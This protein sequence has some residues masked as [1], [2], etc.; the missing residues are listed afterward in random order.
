MEN[1]KKYAY[2]PDY[3][4]PPGSTLHEVMIDQGMSQKELALRTG[5]TP[6]TLIRIFK[7]EQPIT[8]E[9]AAR[10]ELVTGVPARFWNNLEL[11]YRE[12]QARINEKNR[13]KGYISWLK[14][15]PTNE[16]RQRGYLKHSEN[17]PELLRETLA[18]F[19][20]SSVQSWHDLWDEPDVAARRSQC[21]ESSPGPT[22][23]W[24][25]QGELHALK[26][27]CKPYSKETFQ[28]TLKKI[29]ILTKE[30]PEVFEPEVIKLCAESGIALALVP[31]M[32]K[33]PWSGATK[34]LSPQKALI[35]LNLRG[36]GEDKFWFSFFHEA[37]HVLHDSKKDLL[38]NDGTDSDPREVKANFFAAEYL[39]PTRYN[40]EIRAFRSGSDVENLARKLE[41][42]PGIVAGRYQHLTKRWSY[43]KAFIRTFQWKM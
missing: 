1:V 12:Q 31:E 27:A 16:L 18:F 38:I 19:G 13:L 7:G 21:F 6:V 20:V 40:D 23:A 30:S 15:I 35:I 24:I 37:G 9:T 29:R 39:I 3:A 26:N 11:Q 17:E 14:S 5:L 41:I 28:S 36:K 32:K 33:V 25:R 42:S 43:Y 22:A 4:V 34:W 8:Y 2:K 10:L